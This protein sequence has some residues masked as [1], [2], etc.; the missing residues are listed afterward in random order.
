MLVGHEGKLVVLEHFEQ[1]DSSQSLLT[2]VVVFKLHT[3]VV[4]GVHCVGVSQKHVPKQ[5][6]VAL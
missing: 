5:P 1:L 2:L 6:M 3:L 4:T